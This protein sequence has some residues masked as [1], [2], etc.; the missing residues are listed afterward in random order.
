MYKSVR[1]I[2]IE[3]IKIHDEEWYRKN[4]VDLMLGREC[5]LIENRHGSNNVQLE[6]GLTLEFDALVLATGAIP[7]TKGVEGYEKNLSNV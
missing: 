7:L 1:D 5:T 6:D 2:T 4:N 3:D